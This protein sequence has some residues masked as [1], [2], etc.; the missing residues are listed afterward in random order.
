[1]TASAQLVIEG[2]QE[3]I[4]KIEEAINAPSEGD[5][6]VSPVKQQFGDPNLWTLAGTVIT[7]ALTTLGP[8]LLE[9][10][11][12]KRIGYIKYGDI[13]LKDVTVDGFRTFMEEASKKKE[14]KQ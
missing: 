5:V 11:K 14:T 3:A 9:L 12:Q 2:D 6:L 7:A 13:E 1:M 8:I 10:I 4:A